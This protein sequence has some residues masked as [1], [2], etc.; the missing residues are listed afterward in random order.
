MTLNAE[1]LRNMILFIANNEYV[2]DLG[3][4]KLYKLLY[5]SDVTHLREYGKTISGSEYIKYENGP[6]P[7]R[8]EKCLKQL[9]KEAQITVT[10]REYFNTMLNEIHANILFNKLLFSE[11]EVHALTDICKQLGSK[12]AS[13]LSEE[14]H[15]EPAWFYAKTLGKLDPELMYYGVSEDPEGL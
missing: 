10:Q 13:L 12:P 14:S 4:T 3:L 7:S 15:K 6:V 8:G 9:R 11:T 1:K 5:F 2:H